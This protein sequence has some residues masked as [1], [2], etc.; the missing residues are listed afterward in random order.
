[1]STESVNVGEIDGEPVWAC[2]YGGR[3]RED[4]GDRR[5]LALTT[6]AHDG[7]E[8]LTLSITEVRSLIAYVQ[9]HPDSKFIEEASL[10]K[11]T[12]LWWKD[13]R[14]RAREAQQEGKKQFIAICPDGKIRDLL[15]CDA[16]VGQ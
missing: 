6:N 10:L 14:A 5:R 16:E 2:W 1:M 12:T 11:F 7:V 9:S 4:G 15:N 13:A 8:H 3:P